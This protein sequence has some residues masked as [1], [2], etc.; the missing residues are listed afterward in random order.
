MSLG[1]TRTIAAGI[2]G[3]EM[4]FHSGLG[5]E[6]RERWFG[7]HRDGVSRCRERC[8]VV[9]GW[10][11]LRTEGIRWGFD[12]ERRLAGI[13]RYD[14]EKG[15]EIRESEKRERGKVGGIRKNEFFFRRGTWRF[16]FGLEL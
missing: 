13:E 8:K 7:S 10:N 16:T 6:S 11:R 5:L 4:V 12:W 2:H 1:F 15:K 9:W 3:A 14:W